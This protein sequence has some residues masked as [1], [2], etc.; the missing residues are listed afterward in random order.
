M[1]KYGEYYIEKDGQLRLD[2]FNDDKEL[3]MFYEDE[4]THQRV[5]YEMYGESVRFVFPYE[6]NDKAIVGVSTDG[7]VVYNADLLT[8]DALV[9]DGEGELPIYMYLKSNPSDGSVVLDPRGLD[10][11]IIGETTDFRVV[12]DYNLL[13]EAFMEAEGWSEEEAIDWI[14]YNTIRALPYTPKSPIIIYNVEQYL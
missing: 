7:N 5:I 8:S 4:Y 13:V 11:A 2:S 12:Y 9:E 14:S 6:D 1:R 10:S 3:S